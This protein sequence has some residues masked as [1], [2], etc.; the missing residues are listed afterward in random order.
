MAKKKTTTQSAIVLDFIIKAIQEKQGCDVK[1][2]NF[3]NL[4]NVLYDYFIICHG[5][6]RTQVDAI[7]DYV[8]FFVK[9]NTGIYPNHKEGRTNAEWI[10]L[11]YIDV[12]VHIFQEE[13]REFYQLEKLWAD[14]EIS[15]ITNEPNKIS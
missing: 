4:N 14:A 8:D 5:K 9:Q 6:S 15:V 1:L 10:I 3:K 12:V 2:L 11:D 13:K 7:A